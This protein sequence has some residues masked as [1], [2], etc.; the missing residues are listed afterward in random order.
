MVNVAEEVREP[1][2]TLPQAIIAA[3][4]VAT[5]LYVLVSTVAVLSL[6]L[7]SLADSTA[8]LAEI[9]ESRDFPSWIMGLIGMLAVFNGALVQLIMASRVLYGLGSQGLAWSAFARVHPK[10]RTP[11][12]STVLVTA[13]ILSFALGFSLER[14]ARFTSFVVL[15]VF[16]AV[17]ASLWRLKRDEQERPV[18]S[19]PTAVP[20]LGVL[21]CTGMICYQSVE[22]LSTIME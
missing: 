3:L 13:A 17:N 21:L 15:I 10:T 22:W 6:P 7:Q 5:G 8:P 12:I 9:V 19:V 11:L 16:A 20:V 1:R 4:T 2:K 14:L 18:F